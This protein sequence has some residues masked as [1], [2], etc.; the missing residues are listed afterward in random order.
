M[1]IRETANGQL[2]LSAAASVAV[3]AVGPGLAVGLASIARPVFTAVVPATFLIA[4]PVSLPACLAPV[5]LFKNFACIAKRSPVYLMAG[6]GSCYI[7]KSALAATVDKSVS[8]VGYI[9]SATVT[10]RAAT[11]ANRVMPLTVSG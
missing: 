6:G 2:S 10:T 1:I 9:P 7:L 8:T 11:T 4:G 3:L 5:S